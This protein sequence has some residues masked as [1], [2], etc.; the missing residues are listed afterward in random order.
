M[1]SAHSPTSIRISRNSSKVVSFFDAYEK[2]SRC[3]K[4]ENLYGIITASLRC[5]APWL[6]FLL[7]RPGMDRVDSVQDR[8]PYLESLLITLQTLK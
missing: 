2:P 6:R 4:I 5:L 1:D 3:A 8:D 7:P